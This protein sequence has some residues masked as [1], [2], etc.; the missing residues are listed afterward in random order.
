METV[1]KPLTVYR[2][3]NEG[4]LANE[5]FIKNGKQFN[6]G[7]QMNY[8]QIKQALTGAQFTDKGYMSTSYEEPLSH[9][10]ILLRINVKGSKAL[11][12]SNDKER[13][14]ILGRNQKWKITNFKRE[15]ENNSWSRYIIDIAYSS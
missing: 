6:I 15:D 4:F 5:T 2:T 13:E 9:G 10:N 1:T 11:L 12:T 8:E 3:V 7:S 14:I